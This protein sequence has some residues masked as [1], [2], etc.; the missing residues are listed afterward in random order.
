MK[1]DINVANLILKSATDFVKDKLNQV[2]VKAT[3]VKKSK[4]K[5]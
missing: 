3:E 4:V 5:K 1:D 2:V